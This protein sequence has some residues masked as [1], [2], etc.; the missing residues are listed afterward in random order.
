MCRAVKMSWGHLL[1]HLE[2]PVSVDDKFNTIPGDRLKVS[3]G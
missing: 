1:L 2:D 3:N